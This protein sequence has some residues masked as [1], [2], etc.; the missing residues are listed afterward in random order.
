MPRKKLPEVT[1]D[2]LK[3]K[4]ALRALRERFDGM[5]DIQILIQTAE[6]HLSERAV[7]T[8][9]DNKAKNG[10]EKILVKKPGRVSVAHPDRYATWLERHR[11]ASG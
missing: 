10:L 6:P 2:L 7:W 4:P 1:E 11:S 5:E 3:K 9:L 8:L